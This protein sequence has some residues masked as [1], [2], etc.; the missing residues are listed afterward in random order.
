MLDDV[1]AAG[2]IGDELVLGARGHVVL[3]DLATGSTRAWADGALVGVGGDR[4][5][6]R[7]CDAARS[8]ATYAGTAVDPRAVRLETD[9][10]I[11]AICGGGFEGGA[12]LF[13]V[14][15]TGRVTA[16]E[17]ATGRVVEL[18]VIRPVEDAQGL[19]TASTVG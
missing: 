1:H 8:C 11:S 6:W 14:Q 2:V 18:D 16:V 4:I 15:T 9:A 5:V 3:V 13:G 7:G 10:Q 12:W 17:R 19:V